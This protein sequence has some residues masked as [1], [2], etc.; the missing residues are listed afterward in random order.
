MRHPSC[1][2]LHQQFA[3]NDKSAYT[4]WP[5]SIKLY[6]N[7]AEVALQNSYNGFAPMNKMAAILKSGLNLYWKERPIDSKLGTKYQVDLQIKK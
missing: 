3:L 7:V 2:V 6:R 1:G 4:P 5:I